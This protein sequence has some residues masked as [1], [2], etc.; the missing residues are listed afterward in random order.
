MY[1][2]VDVIIWSHAELRKQPQLSATMTKP[3]KPI[4]PKH[5]QIPTGSRISLTTS[6]EETQVQK[7]QVSRSAVTVLVCVTDQIYMPGNCISYYSSSHTTMTLG[8]AVAIERIH[9]LIPLL[10]FNTH[11]PFIFKFYNANIQSDTQ[12][13]CMVQTRMQK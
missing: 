12:S 3:S 11:L 1:D 9:K 8:C 6:H 4:L 5:S 2:I 13:G 7:C 10:R